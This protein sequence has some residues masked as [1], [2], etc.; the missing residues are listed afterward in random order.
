VALTQGVGAGL[1]ALA[2]AAGLARRGEAP[3]MLAGAADTLSPTLLCAAGEQGG[4]LAEGAAFFVLTDGPARALARLAGTAGGGGDLC[5]VEE[6]ALGQAGLHRDDMA[7]HLVY[8]A[9][10][11]HAHLETLGRSAAAAPMLGLC[12]LVE[13]AEL[14]A[15]ISVEDRSGAVDAVCVTAP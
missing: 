15:L 1:A 12:S 6:E 14:P 11:E 8:R 2:L 13:G 4:E 10:G 7:R 5:V 3:W 9:E